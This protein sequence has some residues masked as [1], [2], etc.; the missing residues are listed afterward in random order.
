MKRGERGFALIETLVSVAITGMIGACIGVTTMQMVDYT[1]YNN[2][3]TTVIRQAQNVG[4]WVRQDALMA[5]SVNITDDPETADIE[6]AIM[7]WKDWETGDNY[8]I[9]YGWLDSADPL[10]TLKR[11]QLT[12]D[13]DGVEIGNETTLVADNILAANLSQ[14]DNVLRLFVEV[15][16]GQKKLTKTYQIGLRLEQ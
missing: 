14:Q 12:H 6:L 7:T 9:R 10:K 8:D 4:Y 1:R 16:S 11:K 3:W 2:D 15:Q 13:K 5:E